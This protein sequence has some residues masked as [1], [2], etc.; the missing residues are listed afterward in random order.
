MA[1]K[2]VDGVVIPDDEGLIIVPDGFSD[3]L[4]VREH[5]SVKNENVVTCNMA[6]DKPLEKLGQKVKCP[7]CGEEFLVVKQSEAAAAAK[8]IA[9][10][11]DKK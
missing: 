2:I 5:F 10:G 7:I 3:P 1:D 11:V 8:K 9:E 6:L 4:I